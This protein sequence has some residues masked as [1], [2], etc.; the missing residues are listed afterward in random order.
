MEQTARSADLAPDLTARLKDIRE[1]LQSVEGVHDS[2]A[3]LYLLLA[4]NRVSARRA[5]VLAHISNL[6]L[7]TL[8][9]EEEDQAPGKPEIK[10]LF[11][12]SPKPGI[13]EADLAL[14]D[15]SELFEYSSGSVCELRTWKH[16]PPKGL[17]NDEAAAIEKFKAISS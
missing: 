12:A 16:P 11:D 4:Q 5:A 17:T 9:D 8:P 1:S 2:L 7:R 6:I 14:K 3:E 13:T 15:E 10:F